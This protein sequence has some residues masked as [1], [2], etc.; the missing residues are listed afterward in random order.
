MVLPAILKRGRSLATNRFQG[1][2]QQLISRQGLPPMGDVVFEEGGV[3]DC[4]PGLHTLPVDQVE[5]VGVV[6]HKRTHCHAKHMG[7]VQQNP[8]ERERERE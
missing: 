1:L 2:I 7:V 4:F 3:S 6:H 5:G 8:R